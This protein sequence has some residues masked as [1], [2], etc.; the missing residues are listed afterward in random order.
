MREIEP[1]LFLYRGPAGSLA[2]LP[3]P[4][5]W[6]FPYNVEAAL[7]F[8]GPRRVVYD[9][10]DDLDVFPGGRSALQP[11]HAR[12]LREADV[13]ASVARK[14]HEE[15][16]RVRPDAVYAP[17]GVDVAHFARPGIRPRD[18]FAVSVSGGR[19]IAGYYGALASWFDYDL[20]EAVAHR[21]PD[22]DFLLIGP[23][24][25]WALR[26]WTVLSRPNVRW[27]GPRE[28]AEL[29]DYLAA[30]DVA[31][32]PFV[33]N[34]ITLATSPLKLYEF[35]AGG[36]PVVSTPLPECAAFA[37]VEI[38]SD[39]DAFAAA[40]DVAAEKG[41]RPAY[42]AELVALARAN[43]WEARADAVLAALRSEKRG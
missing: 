1:N 2:D 15:A 22:W 41:R 40:I 35:F 5:L 29:P 36:K 39:P 32:I 20:L 8:P 33:I 24:Y 42:R 30:F 25:H 38:A 4:I 43:S 28:Y 12:A 13:V 14:L 23:L 7:D 6:S 10:I 17:N 31:I 11:S 19:P 21:K 3:A 18:A 37:E 9:W 16:R 26:P 34:D 27:L